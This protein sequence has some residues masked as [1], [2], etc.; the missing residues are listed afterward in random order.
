MR[1]S[2]VNR[3][4]LV[5]GLAAATALAAWGLLW[6]NH[7]SARQDEK[8]DEANGFAAVMAKMKAEKPKIAKKHN[9]LLEARY[10][11][12]DKPMKGVFMNGTPK[13]RAVQAGVRVKLPDGMTWDK[14]ASLTPEHIHEKGLF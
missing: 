8:K 9:E 10:D 2:H 13:G 14:L 11:L 4:W 12:A 1:L 3:A 7:T 6:V 5:S